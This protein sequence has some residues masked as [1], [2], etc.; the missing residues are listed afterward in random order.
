M[1][2]TIEYKKIPATIMYQITGEID[3]EEVKRGMNEAYEVI[4][5]VIHKY[6]MFNLI[7]DLRGL[8]FTDLVVHK[9]WKIWS[10]SRLIE[11]K[12]KY[13]AIVLAD[14]PHTRAE[15]E[16]ME[17][18]TVQFFFDLNEGIIWLQS[19]ATLK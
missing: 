4:D 15:K 1:I 17:T 13:I 18:E 16:L 12:V 2:K 7:I 6:G 19:S 8:S 11:E 14:S 3:V 10:Q 9:T 5:K